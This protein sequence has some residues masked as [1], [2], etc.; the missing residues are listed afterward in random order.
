[1][2]RMVIFQ[3][4]NSYI[5]EIGHFRNDAD[6]IKTIYDNTAEHFSPLAEI[7]SELFSIVVE[8]LGSDKNVQFPSSDGCSSRCKVFNTLRYF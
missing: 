2:E 4:L 5:D 1:M 8:Y 6:A 7:F 3:S